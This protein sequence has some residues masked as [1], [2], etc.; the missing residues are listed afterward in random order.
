[1]KTLKS[2]PGGQQPGR[3]EESD[4]PTRQDLVWLNH[5]SRTSQ[6]EQDAKDNKKP[7]EAMV[8]APC[9]DSELATNFV[10]AHTDHPQSLIEQTLMEQTIYEVLVGVFP[11]DLLEEIVSD[12]DLHAKKKRHADLFPANTPDRRPFSCWDDEAEFICRETRLQP[13]VITDIIREEIRYN[14][15]V[16]IMDAEAVDA[17]QEWAETWHRSQ[18]VR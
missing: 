18:E 3:S 14:A 13:E 8:S 10:V 6:L 7:G 4:D 16:G 12:D 2:T 1:M 5:E 17:Y 11:S 9:Y 15:S